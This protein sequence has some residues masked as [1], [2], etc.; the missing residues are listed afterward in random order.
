MMLGPL[1]ASYQRSRLWSSPCQIQ[2]RSGS[3]APLD[4]LLSL[5][6]CTPIGTLLKATDRKRSSPLAILGRIE[7]VLRPQASYGRCSFIQSPFGLAQWLL[8]TSQREFAGRRPMSATAAQQSVASAAQEPRMPSRVS[9]NSRSASSHATLTTT[10][11]LT[12]R[13]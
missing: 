11:E 4:H 3:F 5:W 1:L 8:G 13:A 6:R 7:S 2:E 10:A 9:T 12:R